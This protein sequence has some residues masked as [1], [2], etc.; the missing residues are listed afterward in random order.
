MITRFE[1]LGSLI[2]PNVVL[3]AAHCV[4]NVSERNLK[5]R[6]GEWDTQTTK[7]RLP[8]QERNVQ[9]IIVHPDFHTK[10]L[11]NDV[12]SELC[13]TLTEHFIITHLLNYSGFANS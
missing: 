3:T 9:A 12:V 1:I 5:V 4:F 2:H 13:L 11:A 8:Y 10:T 6:A 7:E